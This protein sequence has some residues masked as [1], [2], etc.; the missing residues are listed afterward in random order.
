MSDLLRIYLPSECG[1]DGYP[2]AWHK[3]EPA[4]KELVREQAGHRCVRCQHPFVCG[5]TP[6]EWSPCDKCCDHG[7]PIRWRSAFTGEWHAREGI[8]DRLS[9]KNVEV[10]MLGREIDRL[11]AQW[12]VLTVH[13]LTGDKRDCRWWNLCVLDQRCHLQIQ[14]RVKMDQTYPFEHSE[15]FKP[16]AAGY[17]AATYLGEDLT[18]EETEARLDD[19]LALEAA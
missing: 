19:L 4:I 17:Y 1:E 8:G 12:R 18:R 10:T 14:G 9:V 7:G 15:W 13:H 2:I 16:Y 6:S 3:G 5:E 11:E